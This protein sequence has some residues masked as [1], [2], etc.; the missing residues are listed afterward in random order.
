MTS[1]IENERTLVLERIFNAPPA[2][3]FQAYTKAEHLKKW[4]GPRGWDVTHC[5]VDFRPGGIWHYCMK[6]VDKNQGQ[7]FGMESWGKAIYKSMS[8]PKSLSYTDFFS[9]AEGNSNMELPS[10]DVEVEFV[11]V[12]GKTKMITR[13]QYA[14]KEA[15]KTVMDMGML[16]GISQ[17]WDRLD[18][19]L[20]TMK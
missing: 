3:V 6:C 19:H 15:L 5:T 17:T 10:T 9:D 14:T 4:W 13:G 1:R 20:V 18:E 12:D 11:D 16:E 2:V 8:A 7:Y